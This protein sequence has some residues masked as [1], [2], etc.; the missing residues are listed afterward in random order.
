MVGV[1]DTVPASPRVAATVVTRT[2]AWLLKPVGFFLAQMVGFG[3]REQITV[4]LHVVR[5]QRH[6][7]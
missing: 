6:A 4:N 1:F 2:G 5:R 7:G 3:N